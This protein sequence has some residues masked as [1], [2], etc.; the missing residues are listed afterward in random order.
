M[1]L[2]LAN[3]EEDFDA[4]AAIWNDTRFGAS[5]LPKRWNG[6]LFLA[7]DEVSNVLLQDRLPVEG[8]GSWWRC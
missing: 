2:A 7:S 4:Q 5:M 6:R 3:S 8:A 1:Q